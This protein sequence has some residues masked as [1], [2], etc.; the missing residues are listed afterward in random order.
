MTLP[1]VSISFAEGGLGLSG[2]AAV[3]SPIALIGPCSSG[4]VGNVYS[5]DSASPGQVITDLGYGATPQLGASILATP[6]HVP[7]FVVPTANTAGTQSAVTSGG[8]TPPVVTLAGNAL[9]DGNLR[10]EIRSAGARGTATFRYCTDY[11]AATGAGSWSGD[12]LTAATYAMPNTGV[13]LNFAAG[14]YA[15]DN[16]YTATLTG[17]TVSNTQVTDAIDALVAAGVSFSSGVIV[18]TPADATAMGTLFSAV[19]AKADAI[20]TARK[21][22]SWMIS[23]PAPAAT[24]SAGMATWR[25]ALTSAAPSLSH[26]RMVIAA[27]RCRYTSDVNANSYVRSALFPLANRLAGTGPSEHLGRVRS[28]SLRNVTSLEHD[29]EATG[30]LESSRYSTLRTLAGVPGFYAAS[31][32]TFAASGSDYSRFTHR[33]VA[34]LGAAALY[35]AL[36]QYLNDEIATALGTGRILESVA[37]AIDIDLTS[38]VEAALGNHAT[39]VTVRVSRTEDILATG[40]FKGECRIVPKGYATAV[41]FTVAFGK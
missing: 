7:F 6:N 20:E 38:Q 27:G 15:A 2:A 40:A 39:S 34:D 21:Y 30:G 19:S 41:S 22:T 26:K 3:A 35:A 32:Q 11:N 13:T 5:Y 29:E 33:R 36:T 16:V 17:P 9:D 14:T 31:P 23:A 28:G 12:I 10:V 25:S 1:S 24:D 37:A 18:S 8:T 4:V